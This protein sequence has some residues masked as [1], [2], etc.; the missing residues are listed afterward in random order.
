MDFLEI[1]ESNST[2]D[3]EIALSNRVNKN[4]NFFKTHNSRLLEIIVQKP[5]HYNLLVEESG[6]N[7][8][9]IKSKELLY[10]KEGGVHKYVEGSKNMAYSPLENSSW[11]VISSNQ[12]VVKMDE[13]RFPLT[14]FMVNGII[15]RAL[16]EN[17]LHRSILHMPKG[18]LPTTSLFGLA[19][20]LY[21]EYLAKSCSFIHSLFIFEESFDFFRISAFFVDYEY[22]FK[23]IGLNSVYIFVGD[24][25]KKV[26]RE[27]FQRHKIT[28]N[29]IRLELS[30]YS[31][32]KLES[33]KREMELA[34]RQNGR[35]WGSF[36]DEIVGV[37]NALVN[38]DHLNRKAKYPLLYRAK[39]CNTPICVVANGYSLDSSLE[40]LKS[41]QDRVII[42]SSGTAIGPLLNAGITP[43]FHIEI[44][45]MAY[46]VDILKSYNIENLTI[47]GGHII[48]PE[49]VKIAKESYLFLRASSASAYINSPK[50][51]V[52]YSYPIVGNATLALALEFATSLY[53]FGLDISYKEGKTK[54][55]KSSFYKDEE[56]MI[57]KGSVKYRGN[58]GD[59]VYVDSLFALSK[60]MS[61]IA[62][63]KNRGVSVLNFSDGV[64]IDGAK[65]QKIDNISL[66]NSNKSA[67]IEKIKSSFVLDY[68]LIFNAHD[69]IDYI[70]IFDS[71]CKKLL[72]ILNRDIES[73]NE[74]FAIL[75]KSSAFVESF[76]TEDRFL[77]V[78]ING[79]V[80]HSLN[81]IFITTM[82]T[83]KEY[84]QKEY[85][86][87]VSII[88][89]GL[90]QIRERLKVL[91]KFHK[92]EIV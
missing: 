42:F 70:K 78:L 53:L 7:I 90:E 10:P 38:I 27:F 59:D 76:I 44:E 74:I 77:G 11:D 9:N 79:T 46:L 30:L 3:I 6:I 39:K 35:G 29:F 49:I 56:L 12:A 91:L 24:I 75:D 8:Y 52:E 84:M 21:L 31:T 82:H 55:A 43:D 16:Q 60:E 1:L 57:P 54:H 20:G 92:R 34:Q 51:V 5:I 36:E 18:S 65:P 4:I 32:P 25:D 71:F 48:E 17:E 13:E 72:E 15:D 62:I 67:D 83:K 33:A 40:F 45:R 85:I 2:K 69:D 66:K 19:G 22:L 81:A 37:G 14:S 47:I 64:L 26:I 89:I 73:K 23:M 58:F 63:A 41:N 28:T 88:E 61:E 50:R 68:N 87:F 86:D 80:L